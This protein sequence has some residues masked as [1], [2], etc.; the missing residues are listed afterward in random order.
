MVFVSPPQAITP[1]S[2]S[3]AL[4]L[5]EG[6]NPQKLAL[7][8]SLI[9]ANPTNPNGLTLADAEELHS[10]KWKTALIDM[11]PYVA[12][13]KLAWDALFFNPSKAAINREDFLHGERSYSS[14]IM[15]EKRKKNAQLKA[16]V[17]PALLGTFLFILRNSI[18]TRIPQ[19]NPLL[20]E[21][22][23]AVLTVLGYSLMENPKA[24]QFNEQF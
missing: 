10:R 14:A 17:I 23:P 19:I 3:T 1:S 24:K 4:P 9:P 8:A 21:S 2:S 7:P 20:I 11:I 18:K 12:P 22:L 5:R 15:Q 13:L 16:S 6:K